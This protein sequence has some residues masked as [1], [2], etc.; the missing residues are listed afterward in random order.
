MKIHGGNTDM[1]VIRW[2]MGVMAITIIAIRQERL[3]LY[4]FWM[5]DG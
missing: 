2:L 3:W 4:Q 1:T 5:M